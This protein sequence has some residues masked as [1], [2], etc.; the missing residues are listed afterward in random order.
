MPARFCALIL[1]ASLL[2]AAPTPASTA[3]V[4]ALGGI[5]DLIE[6]DSGTLRWYGALVDYPNLGVLELGDWAHNLSGAAR[7]DLASRGGGAHVRLDEAG[8]WGTLAVRFGEDLPAPDPGG[9]FMATYARRLGPVSLGVATQATSYSR[10][11]TVNSFGYLQGES[12]FL[13]L[14]GLGVRWDVSDDMYV[15][16]AADVLD[17]EVDYYDEARNVSHDNLGG[18]N[19]FGLRGRVFRSLTEQLVWVGRVDWFRDTRPVSDEVFDGLVDLDADHIQGGFALHLMPD[20]D[21]LVVFSADYRGIEV[22]RHAYERLSQ[23]QRG[24]REWWRFDA[25]VGL[26]S[27]V[28][29]WLTVRASASYRRHVDETQYVF[30]WP[31]FQ[32]VA[33]DYT[34]R[35]DTP[36]T[37]GFGL[38]L[39][40]VDCDI[41]I[42]DT[43]PFE[44]GHGLDGFADGEHANLTSVTLTR[45]F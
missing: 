36:V 17:S 26:E 22:D 30:D 10:A 15:D 39:G 41:V 5:P 2:A 44:V 19:S 9:W 18:W 28:L 37:V 23:W 7:D 20:P 4:R 45:G 38:H 16:L 24:Y 27:R 3:R 11:S 13:H 35:V 1:V 25:R 6:D 34:V 21:N 8:R 12:R 33:Y 40:A 14:V 31:T 32:E 42:N 43:A 29:P